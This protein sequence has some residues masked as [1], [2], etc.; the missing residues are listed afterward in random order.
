[1]KITREVY[2][3]IGETLGK[4]RPEE[5]GL[6]LTNDGGKTINKF[7]FDSNGKKSGVTY[8]PNVPFLN[9]QI[10]QN[11]KDGYYFIG[12]VHSHPTGFNRPS[13]GK[14]AY[15]YSKG[16]SYTVSDEEC[17][18]KLLDGMKGTNKLYFPIVQSAYGGGKYSMRMFYA[19]KTQDGKY[20]IDEDVLEIVDEEKA[21]KRDFEYVNRLLGCE[22][23]IGQTVILV[24]LDKASGCAERLARAGVS[25]FILI[26]GERVSEEDKKDVALFSEM[27]TYQADVVAK[28]ILD[29]NPFAIVKVLRF[30]LNA[31][32]DEGKFKSWIEGVQCEKSVICLCSDNK[33][34]H[35]T[36]KQYA[37]KFKLRVVE[38]V[39]RTN[40]I[41]TFMLEPKKRRSFRIKYYY[42]NDTQ[43]DWMITGTRNSARSDAVLYALTGEQEVG[44]ETIPEGKPHRVIK[45]NKWA[46]LYREEVIKSKTVVVIG[47]GG[48]RS[49][50]ENL[51][52]S[53][54]QRFVLIDGDRY[55][56]SNTQTQ[57]AYYGDLG[58]NKAEVI[59]EKVKQINPKA[60]VIVK[61]RMLD[62]KGPDE[63]F[64]Q[65]VGPI[66]KENPED[67]LIAACTDSFHANARCSRLALKYGCPFLQA[68]IY[69]GGRVLQIVFFHPAVSKV[70]PRCMMEKRYNANLNADSK[71]KPAES[72]GTS[73]FFTEE[74][75]AKKGY[76]SLGL[77]L[78]HT[79]S[80]PRYANFL[81]DNKW[82]SHNGKHVEDRN[83]MF[84]TM[85]PHLEKHTGIRSYKLFDKWGQMLGSRYQVGVCFFMKKKPRKGCPDCGGK[86]NLLSV[87]GKI[88]DTREGIY[89]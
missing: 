40:T 26:D 28:R 50:I 88:R 13:M 14:G 78:Y 11:N 34:V 82:V 19:M 37:R 66:I 32:I 7:I 83:F 77:L 29:I 76:I 64:A 20:I 12:M 51:A 38:T 22:T 81:D 65:W 79:D 80:D 49:Y 1:M 6:L 42:I 30:Y 72:D 87:K 44:D 41:E 47:C 16:Y 85:D 70:C 39:E 68:G 71:P 35:K 84:Y 67:V 53:G 27:G 55:S 9:E 25:S 74:L 73:V 89:Y 17:F 63:L 5:G 3:Q 4:M 48:S 59:A 57:M 2:D 52:R 61:A 21:W 10:I 15:G 24:G 60:E 33:E 46:S 86:G 43:S 69:P 56:P 58:R 18:Y 54:V 36:T 23:Y 62:E 8:S 75:N 45:V 31:S